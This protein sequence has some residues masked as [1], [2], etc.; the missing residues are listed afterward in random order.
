MFHSPS[1]SQ[2]FTD[3][4]TRKGWISITYFSLIPVRSASYPPGHDAGTFK[5]APTAYP[6][7]AL[8]VPMT[9]ISKPLLPGC[10]T[11]F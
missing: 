6:T 10:P 1:K 5:S 8:N 11:V 4:S 9:A 2:R 3:F 7:R